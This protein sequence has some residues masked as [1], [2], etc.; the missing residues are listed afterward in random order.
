[1][2]FI[3]S[4]LVPYLMTA[5]ALVAGVTSVIANKSVLSNTVFPIDLTPV[6]AV[7]TSQATMGGDV[8]GGS[9]EE[10]ASLLQ[11]DIAR[12]GKVVKDSGAKV[13]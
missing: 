5:E 1:M 7:L 12:W 8:L 6:K 9:P 3:F 2:I 11:A 10:F 13:D 4:G